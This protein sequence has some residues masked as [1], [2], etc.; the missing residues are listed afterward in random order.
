MRLVGGLG[1]G[2]VVWAAFAL[3]CKAVDFDWAAERDERFR[4][5]TKAF[6][7]PALD[8][9]AARDAK[10]EIYRLYYL[11]S[12]FPQVSFRLHVVPAGTGKLTVRWKRG[13]CA[14]GSLEERTFGVSREDVAK[15][16]DAFA[17]AAFWKMTAT[18]YMDPT[19]EHVV[20]SDGITIFVEGV[21]DGRYHRISRS[22]SSWSEAMDMIIGLLHRVARM[23]TVD[24][25]LRERK[26]TGGRDG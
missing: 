6:E 3:P 10:A 17:L 5:C 11:P 9:V 7:E 18:E 24:E 20:C 22:C 19:V 12:F 1:I 16:R 14:P 25:Q 15:L 23:K 4:E 2:L 21:K 8:T 13:Y 26:L